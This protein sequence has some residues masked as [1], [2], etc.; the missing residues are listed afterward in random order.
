MFRSGHKHTHSQLTTCW[1]I[2][3]IV[4]PRVRE[5]GAPFI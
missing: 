1:L 5:A 2:L 4:V 3:S